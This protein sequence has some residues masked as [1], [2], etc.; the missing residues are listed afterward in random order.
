MSERE[1]RDNGSIAFDMAQEWVSNPGKMAAIMAG[2][3][4][5]LGADS[6]RLKTEL[7]ILEASVL[8]P[9]NPKTF[10]SNEGLFYKIWSR[11]HNMIKKG[12]DPNKLSGPQITEMI[13]SSYIQMSQV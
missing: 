2:L 7:L 9:Y 1:P 10:G 12:E 11:L 3:E 8:V 4:M 5:Y 13:R 6:K